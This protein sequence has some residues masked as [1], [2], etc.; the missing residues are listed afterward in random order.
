MTFDGEGDIDNDGKVSD[1]E[2]KNY[3][4]ETMALLSMTILCT[5][6][7]SSNHAREL[8]NKIILIRMKV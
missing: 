5:R 6:P 3:L 1:A 8:I 4:G 7:E 2:L